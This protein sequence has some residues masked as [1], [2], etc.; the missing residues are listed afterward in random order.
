[1]EEIISLALNYGLIPTMFVGLMVFVLKD[2]KRREMKYQQTNEKLA[3]ALEIVKQIHE[4][5]KDMREKKKR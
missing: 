5:I 1:M 4:D 3:S 2:S